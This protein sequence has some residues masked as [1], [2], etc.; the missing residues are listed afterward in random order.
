MVPG[1]AAEV[2]SSA[3]LEWDSRVVHRGR[4]SK[5]MGWG[6]AGTPELELGGRLP[7]EVVGE[8]G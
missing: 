4:K 7:G 5:A 1:C 3:L 8:E 2:S 6:L